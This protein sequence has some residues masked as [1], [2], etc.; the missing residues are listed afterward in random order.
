MG[1]EL[2]LASLFVLQTVGYA[3]FDPFEVET[4]AWRK[5]TKW[6]FIGGLTVL[7][8]YWAGHWALLVP[9]AG[10]VIGGTV[11]VI[12]CRKNGIHPIRATPRRK[13]Y[14]LRGWEWLE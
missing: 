8:Y 4:R 9:L 11:H 2:E 12:W 5:I 13:Y 14:Q 1:V 6:F 7:V 10:G 3:I